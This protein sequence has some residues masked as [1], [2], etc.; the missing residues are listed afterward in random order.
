MKEE[1][2]DNFYTID[3]AALDGQ[4]IF[5][6]VASDK[7]GNASQRALSGERVSELIEI[8]NTPP[9]LRVV[10]QQ[11]PSATG[12]QARVRFA[13]EDATGM[14]KK[15]DVSIDGGTWRGVTPDDGI[16]DGP[17]ETYTVEAPL[18]ELGEH[19]VSLRVSDNSG[20]IGSVRTIVKR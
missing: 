12:P 10:N 4:Y 8:D 14:I 17:R 9:V 18:K 1:L 16:A 3:S 15:A 6:V 20:N 2:K 5:K 19:S 13:V 7:P 11:E